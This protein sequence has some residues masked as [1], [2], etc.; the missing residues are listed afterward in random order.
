VRL[1]EPTDVDSELVAWLEQ[2][3]QAAG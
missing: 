1:G 2:A 3:Y